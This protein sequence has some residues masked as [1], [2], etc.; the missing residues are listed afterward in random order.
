MTATNKEGKRKLTEG[1]LEMV[2]GGEGAV[3]STID[4]LKTLKE[5][6]INPATDTCTDEDRRTIKKE[7]DRSIAQIDGNALKP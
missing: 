5:K 1:E 2:A 7:I 3:Q 4:I 6:A